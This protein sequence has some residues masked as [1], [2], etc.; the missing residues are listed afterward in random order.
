MS[1]HIVE[2][3]GFRNG[4]ALVSHWF[5]TAQIMFSVVIEKLGLPIRCEFKYD[6][7]RAQV[8]RLRCSVHAARRSDAADVSL[9]EKKKLGT[10]PFH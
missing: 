2:F 6:G 5:R 7:M 3:S 9:I 4:F 8:Q 1:P 10:F